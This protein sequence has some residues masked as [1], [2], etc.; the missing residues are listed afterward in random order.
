MPSVRPI[1]RGL[2]ALACLAGCSLILAT[3]ASAQV[4]YPNQPGGYVTQPGGYPATMGTSPYGYA[5]PAGNY[6]YPNAGL[7]TP[8][9]GGAISDAAPPPPLIRSLPFYRAQFPNEAA[10]AEPAKPADAVVII[11]PTRNGVTLNYQIDGKTY[12]IDA[13]IQQKVTSKGE[14]EVRFDRGAN[15]GQTAFK[16]S[17]GR[18]E[19]RYNGS[20]QG[21]DLVRLDPP[22]PA[23]AAEPAPI[24]PAAVPATPPASLPTPEPP[25]AP[26]GV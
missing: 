22:V 15:L 19:F 9:Y 4:V 24:A 17:S 5:A 26:R 10:P 8:A 1:G 21:W 13:G 3:P 20:G 16:L 2:A 23:P 7:L 18:Y 14:F 11:N 25:A 12:R 6:A